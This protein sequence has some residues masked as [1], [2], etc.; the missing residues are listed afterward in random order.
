MLICQKTAENKTAKV[1]VL[2]FSV[3]RSL[4]RCHFLRNLAK[5]FKAIQK[6]MSI[7]LSYPYSGL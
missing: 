7:E 1:Q 3:F 6:Y 5:L 4:I 2:I